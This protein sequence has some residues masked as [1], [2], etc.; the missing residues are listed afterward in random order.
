MLTKLTFLK[1]C[2]FL[3][4]LFI[5]NLSAAV[6]AV[7]DCEQAT[8]LLYDA[9]D[10]HSKGGHLAKQ[11]RLLKKALRYCPQHAEVHN[12]LASVYEEQGQLKQAIEHY[13]KAVKQAPNFTEPW[14]SLG[15]IYYRQKRF[16]L[17]LEAHSQ[18]CSRDADAK[19]RVKEL[20]KEQRYAMAAPGDVIDR[21]SLLVVYHSKRRFKVNRNL[22]DCRLYTKVKSKITFRNLIFYSGKATL[23][24]TSKRQLREMAAAFKKIAPLNIKIHAHTN[25]QTFK[26]VEQEESGKRNQIL[27]EERAEAIANTLAQLGVNIDDIKTFGHGYNQPLTYELTKAALAKNKRIEIK[28]E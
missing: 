25:I 11:R 26:G 5:L 21:E 16:S 8:D 28:V 6:L 13:K 2:Y 9:Y 4:T 17:S 19:A 20:L 18:N 7:E 24:R 3:A 14:Y 12:A 1:S 23:K 27:S 22:F 10:L 15:E